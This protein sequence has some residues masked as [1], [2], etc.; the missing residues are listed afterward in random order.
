[1]I[2][3]KETH[4]CKSRLKYLRVHVEDFSVSFVFEKQAFW[5][6]SNHLVVGS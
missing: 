3:F 5:I 6:I 2:K 1:M 4:K